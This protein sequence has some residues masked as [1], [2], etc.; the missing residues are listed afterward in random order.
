MAVFSAP[1]VTHGAREVEADGV[2]RVGGYALGS[3]T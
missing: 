1:L 2:A 3:Q